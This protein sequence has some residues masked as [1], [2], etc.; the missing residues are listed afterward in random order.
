MMHVFSKLLVTLSLFL[1]ATFVWAQSSDS[2]CL[3]KQAVYFGNGVWVVS[4]M[5]ATESLEEIKDLLRVRM[6]SAEFSDTRFGI[7]YNRSIS[8]F[9][10]VAESARQIL[11]NEYPSL[12]FASLLRVAHLPAWLLPDA[13]ARALNDA[14]RNAAVQRFIAQA[15]S[16]NDVAI[17]VASYKSDIAEGRKVVVVAH[18][19]GNLFVNLAFQ[20]LDPASEQR[21]FGMIPVASPDSVVRKSLVGNV[22]FINDL[23]IQAVQAARS[24]AGLPSVLPFNDLLQTPQ[25]IDGHQFVPN[26][27][28]DTSSTE[29]IRS[30]VTSS[31][32]QLPVP[33]SST[34]SGIITVTLRWGAQPDVDL[35][36]FEPN[37]L[38]IYYGRRQGNLGFLDVDDGSSFGPEHYFASCQN[39]TQKPV[40]AVGTYR[41]GVNYFR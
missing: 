36:V 30:G 6:P 40:L 3:G 27:L 41:V 23:V 35:H 9:A 31:L 19:Q 10:D 12:L 24:L 32:A 2:T 17:H 1:T 5:D 8:K 11:G 20:Q 28:S 21:S 33:T 25:T 39:F 22:T 37:G 4:E 26:Y 29:F 14:L 38:Q 34:Q 18:S 13:L 16:N 7:A 15:S